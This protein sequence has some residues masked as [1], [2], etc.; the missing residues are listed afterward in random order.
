MTEI[1]LQ[2]Y[3]TSG[4]YQ[5]EKDACDA[6][7]SAIEQSEAFR[8]WKEVAGEMIHPLPNNE[9]QSY[10]IDRILVPMDKLLKA[11]W[12]KGLIGVEIKKSGIKAGPPLSQSLDYLRCAWTAPKGIRVLLSY[13]FLFPLAK[14][15][16]TVA[17]FMAQNHFGSCQLNYDPL[18]T[19]HRLEFFIG[20]Q[21]LIECSI[22]TGDVLVKNTKIGDRTGSR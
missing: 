20:E 21:A 12:T 8:M 18:S 16:G 2:A 22:N 13:I 14:C 6:F 7:D 11:G 19:Y 1:D 5:T 3:I 15:H 4:N 10:R 17:S 9:T